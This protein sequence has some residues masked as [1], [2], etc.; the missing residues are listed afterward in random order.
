MKSMNSTRSVKVDFFTN[1]N[2]HWYFFAIPSSI[3]FVIN[4]GLL[5]ATVW[6]DVDYQI[7]AVLTDGLNNEFGKYWVFFYN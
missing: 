3:I 4:L 7:A 5:I 6:Y 2:S 1:K